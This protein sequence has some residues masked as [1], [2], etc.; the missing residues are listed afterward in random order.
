MYKQYSSGW[1]E[2]ICG[3]MFAGKSEELIRRINT[4][5]YAK[6]NIIVFKPLIDDRYSEDEIASH[7]GNK[8]KCY[9]ISRSKDILKFIE[10]DTDVVAIDEVQFFD[11]NI[12]PICEMLADKQIRVMVAGLDKDFK[13]KPFYIMSELLA[14]AEFVTKLSAI[15]V[16]CGAPAT[17]TQR[18]VNNKP[19]SYKDPIILIGASESYEARCR[20][21]HIVEDKPKIKL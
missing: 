11:E 4:L 16:K 3:C 2:V 19:A 7:K 10:D 21:C 13:G 5:E 15:C 6:K 17:I 18:L 8:I 12:I 14:R 20:H 1:I 9:S